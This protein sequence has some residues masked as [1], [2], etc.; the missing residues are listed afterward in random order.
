[1]GVKRDAVLQFIVDRQE[2]EGKVLVFATHRAEVDWL[3]EQ[4]GK[5]KIKVDH[6]DGRVT[7]VEREKVKDAFQEGDLEILVATIRTASEG[8]TFTAT[9]TVVTVEFDWN[10]ARHYQAEAR[11]HRIG[12]TIPV[13]CYYLI[14]LGTIEEQIAAL[15]DSKREVVNAAVGESDRTLGEMGILDALLETLCR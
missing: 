13:T 8:L 3:V 15:I 4:L 12:Q 10:P 2:Q 6:I 5:K 11:A 7:G 14:A 1:M 9:H